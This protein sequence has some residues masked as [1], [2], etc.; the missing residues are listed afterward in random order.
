[1]SK[2]KNKKKQW[3]KVIASIGTKYPLNRNIKDIDNDNKHK[4]KGQR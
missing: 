4:P 1:M 3:E 2:Q